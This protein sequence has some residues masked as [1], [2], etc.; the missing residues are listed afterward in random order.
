MSLVTTITII[1]YDDDIERVIYATDCSFV[2]QD[3]RTVG[4]KSPQVD[5]AVGAFNYFDT[6]KF[7]ADLRKAM[8][9]GEITVVIVTEGEKH[10]VIQW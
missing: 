8:V 5:I 3:I 1:G 10:E 2:I 6:D 4:Y 7:K 9:E